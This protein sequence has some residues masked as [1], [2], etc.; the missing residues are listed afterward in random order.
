MDIW[1]AKYKSMLSL[2]DQRHVDAA[3]RLTEISIELALKT[4]ISATET[5]EMMIQAAIS[6]KAMERDT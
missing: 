1:E 5:L 4:N 3:K 6:L 2:V